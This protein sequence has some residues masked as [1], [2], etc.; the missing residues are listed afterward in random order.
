VSENVTIILSTYNEK[1]GIKKTISEL[2]KY[3][4]DVEIIVVDDNS[5]DGTLEILNSINYPKLKI[6]SRKKTRGLASA[7]L[8]GLINAQGNIIGWV[9]SNMDSIVEKFPEMISNLKNADIV[10]LSRYKAGGRDDRNIVRVISSRMINALARFIL[11][12]KIEDLSSG[13]FVMK[14]DVLLDVVPIASGHG[15]F[16]VEF[17]YNAERKGNKIVELPYSHP[18]DKEGNSKSFPSLPKFLLFGFFYV[19]RLFQ[20]MFRR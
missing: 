9:D 18:I 7:F 4:N 2:I 10:L 20:T 3:I 13:I 8:L 16:M 1:L 12:S 5:P 6:F 19:L 14:R 11:R 15:E 17:L